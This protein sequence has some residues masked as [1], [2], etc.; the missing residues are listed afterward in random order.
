ME[1]EGWD[2]ASGVAASRPSLNTAVYLMRRLTLFFL[3]LGLLLCVSFGAQ[4][5]N[6]K[7]NWGI[8]AVKLGPPWTNSPSLDAL[9]ADQQSTVPLNR[10]Y[11]AG[12]EDVPATPT[13]CR[14]AYNTDT[15]FVVFRCSETNLSFPAI[16]HGVDWYS[17][18][19]S[20]SEQDAAFP[21]QVH[22]LI[23]P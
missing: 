15:L 1:F 6:T 11:R 14:V 17:K 23:Q 2:T 8:S 10:F 22:F 4:G 18:L 16:Q 9:L 19:R 3:S 5:G 21:D 12:G 20:A 13:E 7:L